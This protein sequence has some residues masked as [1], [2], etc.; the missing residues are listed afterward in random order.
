MQARDV[1]ELAADIMLEL[2]GSL[3]DDEVGFSHL[4][5]DAMRNAARHIHA[6]CEAPDW[7]LDLADI[8]LSYCSGHVA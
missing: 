4:H 5:A 3:G 7:A 2:A 6:G 1:H 8:R